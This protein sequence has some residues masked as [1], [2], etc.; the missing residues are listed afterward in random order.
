MF[1]LFN[2]KHEHDWKQ[3][4]IVYHTSKHIPNSAN[5]AT[6]KVFRCKCGA[7][8]REL[9]PAGVQQLGLGDDVNELLGY[10]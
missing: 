2:R 5:P 3:V 10:K 4:S 9:S 1:N 6:A 8:R 7:E